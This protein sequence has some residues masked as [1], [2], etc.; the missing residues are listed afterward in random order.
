MQETVQSSRCLSVGREAGNRHPVAF[1]VRAMHMG[2]SIAMCRRQD[3][4]RM[5]QRTAMLDKHLRDQG[6]WS[7]RIGRGDFAGRPA[8]FLDRDGVIVEEVNYLHRISDV[9][10][11]R[12]V[13]EAIAAANA[14]DIAV[15]VVTNQAGV[16]RGYFDWAQFAE[17]QQYILDE[18]AETG[19][20]VD[21]VLACA[22]HAEGLGELRV[23]AHGWRKPQPGM[24]EEA[25]AS[26]GVKLE[27][28][29][30]VGD[31]VSDMQAGFHAGLPGGALVL[32]GHGA[33]DRDLHAEAL[34]DLMREGF[35][36]E[37][38]EEPAAAMTGWLTRAA[39]KR[40][41]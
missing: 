22:Y 19:A 9:R 25:R 27:N 12:G 28:S 41:S 18:L 4:S 13:A 5:T 36:L 39:G 17:V 10:V 23:D 3:F 26:L 31:T 15:V 16:G 1:R 8:L 35:A 33:R 2:R 21:L 14:L 32:T 37:I 24:L 29:Y 11:I 34:D 38:V 30:I 20:R 7:Q 6:T 40:S